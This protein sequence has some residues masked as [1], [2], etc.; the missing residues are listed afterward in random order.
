VGFTGTIESKWS[1]AIRFASWGFIC[2]IIEPDPYAWAG[3]RANNMIDTLNWLDKENDNSSFFLHGFIDED[4][5]G[6]MGHSMGGGATLI[7]SGNEPRFKVS[8]PLEPYPYTD[9][10]PEDIHIPILLVGGTEDPAVNTYKMI[11]PLYKAG[12]PP[13]FYLN[14]IGMDH[15]FRPPKC[16]ETTSQYLIS[17]LQ[18]YLNRNISYIQHLYGATADQDIANGTIELMYNVS[19]PFC[20]GI[21]DTYALYEDTAVYHLIDLH[22]YFADAEDPVFNLTFDVV[23]V[24]EENISVT[25]NDTHFLSVDAMTGTK[26][27]NRYGSINVT[28]LAMDTDLSI[29]YSNPF[30][31]T[32]LPVNDP[33]IIDSISGIKVVL[34]KPFQM[35]AIEDVWLNFSVSAHDI[36]NDILTYS[37]NNTDFIIDSNGFASF[38]PDDKHV[39]TLFIN[40]SVSDN[41]RGICW[42]N[43]VIKVLGL[44]DPP[45]IVVPSDVT[46]YEDVPIWVE[47]T[48]KDIDNEPSE[49]KVTTSS[50]YIEYIPSNF[51]LKFL[52]LEGAASEIVIV[53][54]SDG[55]DLTSQELYV[56]FISLNDPPQI[57]CL[58][59]I[60]VFED[61]PKSIEVKLSDSD[62]LIS[63]LKVTINSSYIN[64]IAE[65]STLKFLYPNNASSESVLVTVSDG[66]E[67]V[68]QYI[69][70]IFIPVNDPPKIS[71][72][73]EITVIEGVESW[74]KVY[75]EDIDNS[76][77]ELKVTTNSGYVF[78]IASNSTLQFLYPRGSSSEL[79]R[80]TVSDGLA[81]TYGYIGVTLLPSSLPSKNQEKDND[82][83]IPIDSASKQTEK[84][85]KGEEISSLQGIIITLIMAAVLAISIIS[86]YKR[87][88][89]KEA[90]PL[91][92]YRSYEKPKAYAGYTPYKY[93]RIRSY[94]YNY[95]AEK[96]YSPYQTQTTAYFYS[97]KAYPAYEYARLTPKRKL[98]RIVRKLD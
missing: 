96:S 11:Y 93:S 50:K 30:K 52:Y 10:G 76:L 53:N 85:K 55:L 32:I 39:G 82:N 89:F 37:I 71:F 79:V 41:N 90:M 25:I 29:C 98:P 63:D 81:E 34:G 47:I 49:L 56:T 62:N 31:V 12:N 9:P 5:F 68:Y 66:V 70:V 78:F 84:E 48:L 58:D 2:A 13:K 36:E 44:N 38:L 16:F 83:K 22:W 88:S 64:Y 24:S 72:E 7:V 26:N 35:T 80:V 40:L 75:I 86:V 6:A 59:S 4:R 91:S 23:S 74:M 17:F 67:Y 15:S 94:S 33:P 65:N 3:E 61:I 8:V 97:K 20:L 43:I 45:T 57:D 51:T 95:E 60:I 19:P 21:P 73:S 92:C 54:V 87:K 27:D 42:V 77:S 1:F 28:V 14:V 46:V 18:L 69:E